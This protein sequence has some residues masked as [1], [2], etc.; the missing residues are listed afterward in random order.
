[1][2]IRLF[3]GVLFA[4]CLLSG[5]AIHPAPED[6][7]GVD[8]YHIVR[9]IRCETRNAVIDFLKRQL[10]RLRDL[11]GD[12]IAQKLLRQ[13]ESDPASINNFKPDLFPGPEYLRF[14]HFFSPIYYAAIAYDFDLTMAEENDLGTNINFLGPWIS[15]LTLNITGDANRT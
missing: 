11:G 6:V 15:K 14:R 1:M 8:T 4:F 2:C 7:T 12:P 5:C 13:Y 9:Q 3:V 10:H